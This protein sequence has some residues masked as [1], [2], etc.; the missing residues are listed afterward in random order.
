VSD[1]G[2]GNE[3]SGYAGTFRCFLNRRN[4]DSLF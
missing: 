2:C 3:C 1:A 4:L